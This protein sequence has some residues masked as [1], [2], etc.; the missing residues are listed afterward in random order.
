MTLRVDPHGG[1]AGSAKV[2]FREEFVARWLAHARCKE[3]AIWS[4]DV[5]PVLSPTRA[6]KPRASLPVVWR[7]DAG[8][9]IG[10][11]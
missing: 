1:D 10:A 7:S 9:E 2:V 5:K 6:S 4:R 3:K 11:G 8:G